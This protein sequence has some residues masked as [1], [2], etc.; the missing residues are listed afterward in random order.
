MRTISARSL[1]R[2]RPGMATSTVTAVKA[3]GGNVPSDFQSSQDAVYPGQEQKAIQKVSPQLLRDLQEQVERSGLDLAAL[4]R[5]VIVDGFLLFINEAVREKFDA[6]L[7]LRLKHET[8][9]ER[10]TTR[11]GYGKEAK[12]D[13][14]WKTEDYFE[15]M[16]WRN[17]VSQHSD[18]F[19]NGEVEGK[20]NKQRCAQAGIVVQEGL[21]ASVEEALSWAT[22]AIF[23]ALLERV[24]R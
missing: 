1:I 7:L 15:K 22:N 3:H 18:P 8:A 19:E 6:R 9:K 23:K 2:F 4:G 12:P 5:I 17:Y 20:P 11:P 10:R 14:F 21:D 24:G 16:V 13:E